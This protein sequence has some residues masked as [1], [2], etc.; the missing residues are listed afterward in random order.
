MIHSPDLLVTVCTAVLLALA[1]LYLTRRAG[2]EDLMPDWN[3]EP[4]AAVY[5]ATAAWMVGQIAVSIMFVAA[6]AA[7]VWGFGVVAEALRGTSAGLALVFLSALLATAGVLIAVDARLSHVVLQSSALRIVELWRTRQVRREDIATRQTVRRPN[8]PAQLV[9]RFKDP[10]RR[11]VKLPLVFA[12][13]TRFDAWFQPIPDLDVA[14]AAA[15]DAE[16]RNA[17][18]L[19]Q[20]PEERLARFAQARK[21]ARYAAFVGPA[22]YL[23]SSFY[24]HPYSLII[25]LLAMVPWLA[26]ALIA[27]TP[28][29]YQLT[30][31]AR[32]GRPDLT[33]A[34]LGSALIFALRAFSDVH[35]LDWKALAP[36]AVGAGGLLAAAI[37]WANRSAVR[38]W[39][40]AFV[41]LL[42]SIAYGVGA[43]TSANALLDTS[44]ASSY[45]P[46]VLGKHVSGGRSRSYYLNVEPWGPRT[47]VADITVAPAVFNQARVGQSICVVLHGGAL[48]SPWYHASVC[49]PHSP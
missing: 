48:A 44:T 33:A 22:L 34:L 3:D 19:G 12:L 42:V 6:G 37:T 35:I 21:F 46:V 8:S 32:S 14:A 31:D 5:R 4:T 17:P 41:I 43:A 9:L 45:R 38:R 18:E 10:A 25:G 1:V 29:V 28:G 16:I 40:T 20:T 11:A 36:W 15:L 7:G 2:Q 39:S 26:V 13:D 49:A 23:W 24:P 30:G 27:K 47:T